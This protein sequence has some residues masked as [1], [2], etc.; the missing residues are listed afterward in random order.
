MGKD[1][2]ILAGILLG[3]LGFAALVKLSEKKC[4]ICSS[5]IPFGKRDCPNC[6]YVIS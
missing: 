3:L 5:M 4:P 1:S 6:G 2:D